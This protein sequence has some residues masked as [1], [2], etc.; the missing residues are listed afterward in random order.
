MYA[1]IVR[2]ASR[3]QP[4]L[5]SLTSSQVTRLLCIAGNHCPS[6]PYYKSRSPCRLTVRGAFTDSSSLLSSLR[7][8]MASSPPAPVELSFSSY[9]AASTDPPGR[10]DCDATS[11]SERSTRTPILSRPVTRKELALIG[12]RSEFQIGC[13]LRTLNKGLVGKSQFF[14]RL[15]VVTDW[16]DLVCILAALDGMR[17]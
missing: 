14:S 15:P 2:N 17:W 7:L 10:S 5:A 13:Q 4:A 16:H 1:F 11:E 8:M 3:L 12:T 6:P 9:L